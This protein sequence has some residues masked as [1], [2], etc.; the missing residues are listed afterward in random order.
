MVKRHKKLSYGCKTAP[1][2]IGRILRLLPTILPFDD[3][4]DGDSLELLGSLFGMGKSEWLDY[5][6]VDVT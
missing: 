2:R 6:P 1:R 5:N 3:I 4:N